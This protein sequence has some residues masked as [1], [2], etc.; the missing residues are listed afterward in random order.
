MTFGKG[1]NFKYNTLL[2][3]EWI[4]STI[5]I[6]LNAMQCISYH[7]LLCCRV[8]GHMDSVCGED[9]RSSVRMMLR[10]VQG[11]QHWILW[12]TARENLPE[13]TGWQAKVRNKVIDL[14][15]SNFSC[16]L[17]YSSVLNFICILHNFLRELSN[18]ILNLVFYQHQSM[19]WVMVLPTI[20]Q[21]A[22]TCRGENS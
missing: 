7:T 16:H 1:S 14:K 8:W 5:D 21:G 13:T 17:R 18:F 12:E 22:C 4:Q 19:L 10:G 6:P 3:Y 20:P 15:E 9:L 11:V 2:Q